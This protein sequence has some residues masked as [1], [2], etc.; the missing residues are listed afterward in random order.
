MLKFSSILGRRADG[1]DFQMFLNGAWARTC[2]KGRLLIKN[3]GV[4]QLLLETTPLHH[5][6][7]SNTSLLVWQ[8]S[9]LV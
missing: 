1:Q 9:L 3:P 7:S 2:I 5:H 8:L 4:I 6:K